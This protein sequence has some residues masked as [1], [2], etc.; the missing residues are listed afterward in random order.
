MFVGFYKVGWVDGW[1]GLG[2]WLL[3]VGGEGGLWRLGKEMCWEW[4]EWRAMRESGTLARWTNEGGLMLFFVRGVYLY[5]NLSI[6][7]ECLER[8]IVQ[9]LGPDS[10]GGSL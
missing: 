4:Q 1:W 8:L 6:W 2:I 3:R 10:L 5:D 7:W 9:L